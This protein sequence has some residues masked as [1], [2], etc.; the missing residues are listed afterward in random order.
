MKES[1]FIN[2]CPCRGLLQTGVTNLGGGNGGD[3]L[4][5]GRSA[6]HS[7]PF[8]W[9]AHTPA[10]REPHLSTSSLEY[11]TPAAGTLQGGDRLGLSL[12]EL[13]LLLITPG[14]SVMCDSSGD[15]EDFRCFV[16]NP[17]ATVER[18]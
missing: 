14:C 16:V 2:I 8:A 13:E 4:G 17:A 10:S 3:V 9:A 5:I 7:F 11:T 1:H 6:D 12:Q 18:F 15:H